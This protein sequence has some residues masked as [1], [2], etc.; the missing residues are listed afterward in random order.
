[1]AKAWLTCN[2]SVLFYGTHA[3]VD[4]AVVDALVQCVDG[5]R[6]LACRSEQTDPQRR[7]GALTALFSTVAEAEA[8]AL[9]AVHRRLLAESIFRSPSSVAPPPSAAAL[10]PAVL[11]LV[12]ALSR[13]KPLLLVLEAVHL[14]DHETSRVL[15]F[16]AG[17][18]RESRVHMIAVEQVPGPYGP[19]GYVICPSPLVMI[20][21]DPS[22]V[23]SA[24]R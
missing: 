17:Q 24:S 3:V 13:S 23:G 15:E 2:G 21:L 10:G 7:L 11:S 4:S 18:A 16:V 5:R 20:G 14:L 6:V 12:E 8:A 9:P 19:Q 22:F 1:M